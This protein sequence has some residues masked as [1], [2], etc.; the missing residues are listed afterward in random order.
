MAKIEVKCL[1]CKRIRRIGARQTGIG[2][3]SF[4]QVCD[5]KELPLDIRRLSDLEKLGITNV[6][7][8]S[9]RSR[10]SRTG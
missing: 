5:G 6:A 7:E 9:G 2:W 4:C 10:L 3:R 8:V 1:E